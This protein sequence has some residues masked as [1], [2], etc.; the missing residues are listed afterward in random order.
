MNESF[1]DVVVQGVESFLNVVRDDAG[2]LKVDTLIREFY[3]LSS[4]KMGYE[5]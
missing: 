2:V 4:P 1:L 3:G 5:D